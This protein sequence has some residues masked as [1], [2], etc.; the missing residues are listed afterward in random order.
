MRNSKVPRRSLFGQRSLDFDAVSMIS[1]YLFL[2]FCIPANLIVAPLGAAGTPAQIFGL[3]AGAWWVVSWIAGRG[4]VPERVDPIRRSVVCFLAAVLASYVA[5]MIRPIAAIEVRGADR[6]LLG[7]LAWIGILLASADGI[8]SRARLDTLMRRLAMAGGFVASVGLLQF[9]TG[10]SWIDMISIPGF[11]ANTDLPGVFDRSGFSR[12]AGT[13]TSPIEFGVVLTMILPVSLHYAFK[14]KY[15]ASVR[16]WYPVLAIAFAIPVSV[17]RSA[18]VGL[19]VVLAMVVPVWPKER[20]HAVYVSIAVMAIAV[21]V[22]IPGLLG[23]LAKLFSGISGDGSA[24]SRTDSYGL[25]WAFFSRA[26]VFG[27]GF[28]TFLPEYR[29]LDNQ[30][31]GVAIE[32]GVVGL[33]AVLGLF[34]SGVYVASRAAMRSQD[35]EFKYLAQ[36]V[37][38]CIAAGACSFATFDAFGFPLVAGLV[39]VALGLAVSI[40]RLQSSLP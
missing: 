40:S 25:A 26:P 31:L 21:Y 22:A 13:G 12:P 1:I 8:P 30:Y 4:F 35:S 28:S 38:A 23:T 11:S 24:L 36:T 15:R 9:F 18:I 2:L 3:V 27:R 29:I 7:V 10:R 33:V 39:F 17:S 37:A 16:R 5:A 14:D 6:G 19:V 20:R 32:M 34:V